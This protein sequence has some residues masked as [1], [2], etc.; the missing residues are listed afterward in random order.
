MTPE[1]SEVVVVKPDKQVEGVHEG[2][3]GRVYIDGHEVKNVSQCNL[4]GV[5]GDEDIP[6]VTLTIEPRSI[7]IILESDLQEDDMGVLN[8]D[9]PRKLII[10]RKG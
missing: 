4:E 2:A 7:R 5:I 1:W 3:C 9:R 10:R 8:Y 6:S